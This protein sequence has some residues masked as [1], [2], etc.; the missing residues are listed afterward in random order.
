M[1]LSSAATRRVSLGNCSL[2]YLINIPI[3]CFSSYTSIKIV[4][5]YYHYQI[6]IKI[7][8]INGSCL[9][10]LKLLFLLYTSLAYET[11]QIRYI[12]IIRIKFGF[13]N[14]KTELHK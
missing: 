11:L 8:A 9:A 12:Y 3:F 1:V 14:F 2:V 10:I 5:Q 4:V 13:Y 6:E 7:L